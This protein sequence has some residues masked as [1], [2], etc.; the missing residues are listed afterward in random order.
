M[1]SDVNFTRETS[2]D[3]CE[4]KISVSSYFCIVKMETIA[5][6]GN[7][8]NRNLR[9]PTFVTFVRPL[10]SCAWNDTHVENFSFQNCNIAKQ[11]INLLLLNHFYP[12]ISYRRVQKESDKS[13]YTVWSLVMVR[14][15]V[16][17]RKW[18]SWILIKLN[19]SMGKGSQVEC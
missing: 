18:L 7:F 2:P 4:L 8:L 10:T 13:L 9:V 16:G 5:C 12:V 3:V 14:K 6:F 15:S 17:Q 1:N 19:V 11:I